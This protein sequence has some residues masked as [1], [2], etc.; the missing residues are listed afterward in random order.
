MFR[1]LF[2]ILFEDLKVLMR[3]IDVSAKKRLLQNS[4]SLKLCIITINARLPS[5]RLDL[6]VSGHPRALR[7]HGFMAQT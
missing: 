5:L 1:V 2:S 7:A 3:R 6:G 4:P